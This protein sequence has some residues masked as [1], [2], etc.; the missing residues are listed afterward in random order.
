MSWLDGIGA[1]GP[2]EFEHGETVYR[3]RARQIWDPMSQTY[4]EGDWDDPDVL[5]L[6]NAFIAQ[7]ST[8]TI[9][10]TSRTGAL[11]SKSLY[12]DPDADVQMGDRIR[13]GKTGPVFPV[14]GIPASDTNPFSGWR[15]AREVPLQRAAG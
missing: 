6:E 15:P 10:E 8:S 2:M 11:E 1:S 12:C 4:V 7:S 5:P 14:D 9:G 13:Q 3:L